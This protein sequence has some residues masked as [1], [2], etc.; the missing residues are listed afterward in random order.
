MD[1]MPN[2]STK[3]YQ[4]IAFLCILLLKIESWTTIN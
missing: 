2:F 1:K 4:G 3:Q